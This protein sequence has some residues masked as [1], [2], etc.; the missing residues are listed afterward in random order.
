MPLLLSKM[1]TA[2]RWRKG[3]VGGGTGMR[4]HGFKGGTGTSSRVV[5]DI[6]GKEYTVGVSGTGKPWDQRVSS[7]L[8]ES[9]WKGNSWLWSRSSPGWRQKQETDQ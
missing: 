9:L 5:K 7:E 2:A 4:C 1:L 6:P 3:N 8:R